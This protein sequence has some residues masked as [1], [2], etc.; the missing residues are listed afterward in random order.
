MAIRAPDGAKNTDNVKVGFH[1][2]HFYLSIY[3][4]QAMINKH[5]FKLNEYFEF[6]NLKLK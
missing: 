3:Y 5:I 1:V 6:C 2:I 4:F